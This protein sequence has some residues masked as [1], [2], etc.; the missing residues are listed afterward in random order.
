MQEKL[1]Y[2]MYSVIQGDDNLSFGPIGL[3]EKDEGEKVFTISYDGLS[4]V[5]SRSPVKKWDISRKNMIQH[6]K[7]NEEVMK[8]KVML[9]IRF[10]TIAESREDIIKKFLKRKK[11]ELQKWLNYLA[12]KQEYGLRAFWPNKEQILMELLEKFPAL[13]KQRDRLALLPFQ[14]VRNDMVIFG[15]KIKMA[16]QQ[17]KELLEKRLVNKLQSFAV[18]VKTNELTMDQMVLNGAFLI[19][20]EKQ[21]DFDIKVNE[22][23]TEYEKTTRFKYIGPTPPVNF[24]EIK[25]QW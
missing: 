17:N 22:L 3:S 15:E 16:F 12:D 14:K 11:N 21:S 7:V 10:C 5:V 9:P 13:K 25:V 23:V 2:Y 24:V 4:C 8:D 6:Q 1:G 18:R 19:A 20:K